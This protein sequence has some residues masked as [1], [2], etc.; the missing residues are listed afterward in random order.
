VGTQTAR[1]RAADQSHQ[2]QLVLEGPLRLLL[3]GQ[4]EQLPRRL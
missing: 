4:S 3:A 2:Q 1:S